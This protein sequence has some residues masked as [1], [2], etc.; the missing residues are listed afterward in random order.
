MEPADGP[1]LTPQQQRILAVVA[2]SIRERGYPPTMREIAA[3][4]GLRS[5]STVAH[6]L[7]VLEQHGLLRRAAG[8][9]RAVELRDA[10]PAP[11]GRTVD[12]PLLG[13][14]AAGLPRLADQSPGDVLTLPA[15]LVGPGTC[16]ALQVRGDSMIEAGIFEGD[17][18]VIRRQPTADD[19]DI[20]AALLDDEAT[21][22]VLR[23]R[24]GHAELVPRNPAYP[25]LPADDATIL[26]KAVCVLRSLP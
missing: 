24:A 5:P 19:G 11:P 13:T 15:A 16:F 1:D 25:V 14:V 21:I 17:T 20:V 3:R 6:H 23:H 7:Q 8:S 18:V 2:A 26:G 4:V 9:P 22:K 12:V 10:A